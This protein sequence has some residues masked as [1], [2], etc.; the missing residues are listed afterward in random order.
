MGWLSFDMSSSISG[1]ALGKAFS[2]QPNHLDTG[3]SQHHTIIY[4]F[5]FLLPG[6]FHGSTPT[7]QQGGL[8]WQDEKPLHRAHYQSPRVTEGIGHALDQNPAISSLSNFNNQISQP[9]ACSEGIIPQ[10]SSDVS[11]F[12]Q[13]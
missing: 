1:S 8:N 12:V 2:D 6:L 4:F 7:S 9:P 5:V 13:P 10:L 3:I 11:G